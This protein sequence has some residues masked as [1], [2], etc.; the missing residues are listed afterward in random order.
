MLE[1]D[2]RRLTRGRDSQPLPE[3]NLVIGPRENAEGMPMIFL[4]EGA[5]VEG[6]TLNVKE[7]PIYIGRDAVVME[8]ACLRGPI[9]LLPKAQVKIGAKIYG[10]TTFGPYC[11]V[12][13]RCRTP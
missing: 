1:K 13:A 8:G 6:A 10:A 12:G 11:K 5:S 2:Y 7:G 9:A 3:N 4:E